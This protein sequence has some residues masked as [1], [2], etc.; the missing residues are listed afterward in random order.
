MVKLNSV[1]LKCTS[2]NAQSVNQKSLL[3]IDYTLHNNLDL[4]FTQETW[5][6]EGTNEYETSVIYMDSHGYKFQ[7]LQR[8]TR[9]RGLG[10]I[11]R[12]S[13]KPRITEVTKVSFFQD[14]CTS[15]NTRDHRVMA[16]AGIYHP[17]RAGNNP[18]DSTFITEVGLYLGTFIS[19][20]KR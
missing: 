17:P 5:T 3:I 6:K 7:N 16:I 12:E 9:G 18:M 2:I 10:V 20:F 8:D 4:V 19:Q 14:Y 1:N 13:H 11:Y 15:Q